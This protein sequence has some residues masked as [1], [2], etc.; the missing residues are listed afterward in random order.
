MLQSRGH[1]EL[2]TTERLNSHNQVAY[3]WS[4]NDPSS[5]HNQCRQHLERSESTM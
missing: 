2:D 4:L 1:K 3:L 5:K